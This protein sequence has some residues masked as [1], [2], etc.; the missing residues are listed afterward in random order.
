MKGL[1][2]LTG[3]RFWW[4]A[5]G[6]GPKNASE[7]ADSALEQSPIAQIA[8][9]SPEHARLLECIAHLTAAQVLTPALAKGITLS[10]TAV[11]DLKKSE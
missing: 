8:K 4:L 5:F 1:A 7:G 10:L 11:A 2:Q 3:Y 6:E 9:A